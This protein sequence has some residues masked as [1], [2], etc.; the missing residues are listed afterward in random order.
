MLLLAV[1]LKGWRLPQYRPVF[2]QGRRTRRP[3]VTVGIDDRA[4]HHLISVS[5]DSFGRR[6][7]FL[8]LAGLATLL[9]QLG[10]DA[11][12]TGLMARSDSGA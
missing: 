12:P 5:G 2:H 11:G 3:K 10:D 7:F 4:N 6:V 9:H 1:R 8:A